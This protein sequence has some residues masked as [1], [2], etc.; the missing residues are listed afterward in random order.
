MF[1]KMM[2]QQLK[3]QILV[4]MFL[5]YYFYP[6]SSELPTKRWT[7]FRRSNCFTWIVIQ[8][9]LLLR[10]RFESKWE[11]DC[12]QEGWNVREKKLEE[13]KK[14]KEESKLV[15]GKIVSDSGDRIVGLFLLF[16]TKIKFLTIPVLQNHILY[17]TRKSKNRKQ[18]SLKILLN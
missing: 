13:Q 12:L 3:Q 5:T 6:S 4:S 1:V 17:L 2:L 14:K 9:R 18:S 7:Q 11:S 10:K 16:Q 8:L 15:M